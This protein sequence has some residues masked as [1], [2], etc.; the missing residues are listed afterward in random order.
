MCPS[1]S[2]VSLFAL[3]TM[4]HTIFNK[5]LLNLCIVVTKHSQLSV[6]RAL[7]SQHTSYQRI[8]FEHVP[9]FSLHFSFSFMNLP[10]SQSKFS[11]TRKFA[12]RHQWYGMNFDFG[13]CRVNFLAE[14]EYQCTTF[15]NNMLRN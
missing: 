8:Q 12:L 7:I 13:I 6:S 4:N 14:I 15:K 10:I 3:V 11:G 9:Y 2:F 5:S 1:F